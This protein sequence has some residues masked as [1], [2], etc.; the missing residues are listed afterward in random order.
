MTL[1]LCAIIACAALLCCC[2]DQGA[3]MPLPQRA[4]AWQREWT[5]AVSDA[6]KNVAS[7][8]LDGLVLLGA[9]IVWDHG[10]PKPVR[11][12][13]DWPSLKALNKPVGIAMRV[14][15]FGGPFEEHGEITRSLSDTAKS[16][17]EKMNES[18]VL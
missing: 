4:Y 12:S 18:M 2:H 16:L 17:L 8:K 1:R 7:S 15:P 14:A 3:S 5:P 11:S 6:V 13:I 9:E 10:K